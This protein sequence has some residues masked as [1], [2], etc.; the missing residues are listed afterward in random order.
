MTMNNL[1]LR[2][3]NYTKCNVVLFQVQEKG[4]QVTLL[5]TQ[6]F[7]DIS[8]HYDFS[9]TFIACQNSLIKFWGYT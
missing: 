2:M 8:R 5:Y 9:E 3:G 6:L 1:D 7:Q 4:A